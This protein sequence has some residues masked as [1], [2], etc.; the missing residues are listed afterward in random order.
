MSYQHLIDNWKHVGPFLKSSAVYKISSSS[1]T[2]CNNILSSDDRMSDMI[3][4]ELVTLVKFSSE[5]I[6]YAYTLEGDG[7]MIFR[8]DAIA[9][10]TFKLVTDFK[11]NEGVVHQAIERTISQIHE[12]QVVSMKFK[13]LLR[14]MQKRCLPLQCST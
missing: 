6:K 4:F 10:K 3:S 1:R 14:N 8:F 11:R 12:I 7:L 9:E 5:I 13:E 2:A